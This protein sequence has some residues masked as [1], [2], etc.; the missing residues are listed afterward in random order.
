[1]AVALPLLAQQQKQPGMAAC[2]E[3]QGTGLMHEPGSPYFG[4]IEGAWPA[5]ADAR[6]RHLCCWLAMAHRSTTGSVQ[7]PPAPRQS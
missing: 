7:P 6:T 5:Q 2:T 3:A 1:M 4:D